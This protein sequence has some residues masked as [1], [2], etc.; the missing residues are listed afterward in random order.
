MK[1]FYFAA[2]LCMGAMALV[3]CSNELDEVV[4][5]E[6]ATEEVMIKASQNAGPITFINWKEIT[7]CEKKTGAQVSGPVPLPTK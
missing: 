6:M 3:S 1:K 4:A 5:E 7:K 2:M